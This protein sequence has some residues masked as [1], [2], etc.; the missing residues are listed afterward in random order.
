ML[1][2]GISCFYHDSAIAIVKNGVPIFCLQ[3]ERV[4]RVKGDRRFPEGALLCALSVLN[5]SLRDFDSIVYYEDPERK[6]Q[7]IVKTSAKELI[8]IN[9]NND[10]ALKTIGGCLSKIA[11]SEFEWRIKSKSHHLSHAASAYYVSPF[12]FKQAGVLVTDG[13]GEFE[14]T[15]LWL[16]D[17]KQRRLC[18]EE[19]ADFPNSLGIFYSALTKY[20]GFKINSGEYKVMGLAPYGDP[21]YA[22][23]IERE[24]LTRAG[25]DGIFRYQLNADYICPQI[26]GSPFTSAL[27]DLLGPD[28]APES[29]L[30]QR[31]FDIA[32]STQ[33]VLERN[34]IS[35]WDNIFSKF[36]L[37]FGCMAGGV[38]LN[39]TA[40]GKIRQRFSEKKFFIQPAAGDAGGALGAA[41]S[42]F[43]E[44]NSDFKEQSGYAFGP[45]LG[46]EY[47]DEEILSSIHPYQEREEVE[48]LRF[49]TDAAL[50]RDCAECLAGGKVVGWFQGRSEF[51]P[52]ALGARS[53]LASPL[54]RD[55]QHKVNTKVKFRESFRPFAPSMLGEDFEKFF[56]GEPDA[57]M[58]STMMLKH[59][60]FGT[61]F[62]S[63]SY[64]NLSP[65]EKLSF[66]RSAINPVIHV[67]G[68][69][70]CQV[71]SP[72]DN[73]RFHL[74]LNEFKRLTGYGILVNT[75]F[76]V[77]GEPIVLHP[78]D[79]LKVFCATHLDIL[80]IGNYKIIKGKQWSGID[81]N[82]IDTMPLD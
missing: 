38:A 18:L 15:S 50:L 73:K 47:H 21:C 58:L 46:P 64:K 5:L 70:R 4:T 31:H 28:R 6:M 7:R 17:Q 10:E 32:A 44:C 29:T 45:F 52:R 12:K 16:F 55:M 66:E 51:G 22:E 36:D 69:A 3:E 56:V 35:I 13:V 71:V 54:I 42:E 39:C 26:T 30:E 53:I 14:S 57:F 1:I 27:I 60:H 65:Y 61:E 37:P 82:F 75:S 20:L 81:C 74:L 80:Y 41:L 72:K 8:G 49:S 34:L 79:A 48:Y 77:R 63:D 78:R 62:L 23:L 43:Y 9:K 11:G 2:L 25:D 59:E 24:V 68:S 40:N 19:S 33:L 76:N 67:D